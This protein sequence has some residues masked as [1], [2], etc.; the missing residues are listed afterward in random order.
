MKDDGKGDGNKDWWSYKPYKKQMSNDYF[1]PN[2]IGP[3]DECIY[4]WLRYH[5]CNE[6][7][8]LNKKP[9]F[10]FE[11]KFFPTSSPSLVVCV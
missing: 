7:I 5:I 11:S 6:L 8:V 4:V 1:M 9:I 10:N 3:N 2:N